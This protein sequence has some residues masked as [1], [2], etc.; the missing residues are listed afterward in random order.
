MKS[1][2]KVMR[3]FRR[4]MI[5]YS[6]PE[7]NSN[8]LVD[9]LRK[10]FSG[11]LRD[12]GE[13]E[14]LEREFARYIGT[15]YAVSFASTRAGL[16]YVY[17]FFDCEK[18][19]VVL[20]S[21]TCIPAIDAARWAGAVPYFADIDLNSYNPVFDLGIAGIKNIGAISL[22]YLYGLVGNIEP[23]LEF[24][25]D[26]NVPI[27]EDSAIALGGAFKN[28][29]VGSLGD[30]GVFS[31]QDSKIITSWRGGIITTNDSELF[32]YLKEVQKNQA[33]PLVAKVL[34]NLLVSYSRRLL[35]RS[36]VYGLTFYPVKKLMTSGEFTKIL[37]SIISFNPVEALDGS[38]P[39]D[40]SKN[41]LCRF[42]NIQASIVRSSLRR[43]DDIVK[44]RRRMA[45]RLTEELE[46]LSGVAVP[47]EN[48]NVR[49]AYGRYPMRIEGR[50][51]YELEGHFLKRGVEIALNYTYTCPRTPHML[52]YRFNEKNYP[53]AVTASRETVLLPFH[54]RLT[55]TDL[56]TI[57]ETVKGVVA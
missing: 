29:R 18:K 25:S 30:A 31:F 41:D 47:V 38:S 24:A 2:I 53:N 12:G 11:S 49:H 36:G 33:S 55:D 13:V 9:I 35:S 7:I 5:A 4:R 52:K 27:I 37:E 14:A 26:N 45:K 3:V 6:I 19:T 39:K 56:D 48:G 23:F 10:T 8:V 43:I 28:K 57:I 46:N 54:T 15:K 20:P 44:T 32:H 34:L 42:V 50:S 16:Y 17:R 51:K 1:W 40:I 22:S 21:Y